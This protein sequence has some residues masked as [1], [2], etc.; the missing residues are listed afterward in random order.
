VNALSLRIALGVLLLGNAGLLAAA[1]YDRL[2]PT[3]GRLAIEECRLEIVPAA[4]GL[5]DMLTGRAAPLRLRTASRL[6]VPGELRPRAERLAALGF[7]VDPDAPQPAP[8]T[9]YVAVEA[10]GPAVDAYAET[11]PPETARPIVLR[12][13]SLDEQLLIDRYAGRS[14]V[15]IAK[16]I[17]GIALK[18]DAVR[19]VPKLRVTHLHADHADRRALAE[20]GASREEPCR[21]R[22]LAEIVFGASH[23]PRLER[24]RPIEP[25]PR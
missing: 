8:R 3:Y 6:M 13:V 19:L 25:A 17:A 21:S 16:G 22:F 11:L 12:D 20:F 14:G 24:L 5:W 10:H 15:A 1:A 23:A 9:A 7:S 2:G 18:N 4:D